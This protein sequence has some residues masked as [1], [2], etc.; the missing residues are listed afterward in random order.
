MDV[1]TDKDHIMTLDEPV[2]VAVMLTYLP[3]CDYKTVQEYAKYTQQFTKITRWV[4]LPLCNQVHW[5]LLVCDVEG[6]G[7]YH[8]DS[9]AGKLYAHQSSF[10][11]S[12]LPILVKILSNL[13]GDLFPPEAAAALQPEIVPY[14][15][16]PSIAAD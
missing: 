4:M 13:P 7:L 2:T 10:L 5:S 8:L 9:G 16:S 3:S 11:K 6:F 14:P 1:Y 15:A 12:K